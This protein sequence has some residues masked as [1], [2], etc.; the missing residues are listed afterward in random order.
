MLTIIYEIILIGFWFIDHGNALRWY[1]LFLGLI[2]V[3]F[4]FWD[5]IDERFKKKQNTSDVTQYT[6]MF[7]NVPRAGQLLLSPCTH[8]DIGDTVWTTTWCL[9][10]T[11]ALFGF[12]A[13]GYTKFNVRPLSF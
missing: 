4:P 12:S 2:C 10:S 3:L 9:L 1:C 13:I 11:A 8:I 7:P 6:V 5:L